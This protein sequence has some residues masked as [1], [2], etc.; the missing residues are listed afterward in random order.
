VGICLGVVVFLVL[1]FIFCRRRRRGNERDFT[2]IE[3]SIHKG[4]DITEALSGVIGQRRKP[5][6]QSPASEVSLDLFPV[7][8][9]QTISP[10]SRPSPPTFPRSPT[11]TSPS[12][13][14]SSRDDS[15]HDTVDPP[16]PIDQYPG[17]HMQSPRTVEPRNAP[18]P[19]FSRRSSV[20]RPSGPRPQSYRTSIGDPRTSVFTPLAQLVNEPDPTKVEELP[21][22]PEPKIQKVN[23]E[24][25]LI[26]YSF[27]DMN[28]TSR[29]SS[30]KEG[31]GKSRNSVP[32][33]PHANPDSP[34]R[35]PIVAS[36]PV[37]SHRDSD[38]HRESRNSKQ[39]SLS[40][41]I[42]QLPALKIRQS[43]ELHPYSP[44][45]PH[46]SRSHRP[47]TGGAS[48]TEGVP[49]TEVSEIRFFDA[50]ESSGSNG[51]LQRSRPHSRS[52]SPKPTTVT[53]QI[54]QKLFGSHQGE[55]P[56]DGLLAQKRP[57]RRKQLSVSTF[58]TPPRA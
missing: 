54:Y 11:L 10:L 29:T 36:D 2:F 30:I 20:P 19:G 41:V 40:A 50:G 51:S 31:P 37:R 27:L 21:E 8:I 6:A 3:P 49:V 4:Y 53:S 33:L 12:Q 32:P 57:L 24:G 43:T 47:P 55:V 16:E 23:E 35:P 28:S 38:R 46:T 56:P 44:R 14:K 1:G 5:H 13:T 7:T 42:R 15:G 25:E 45:P 26:T 18:S 34:P 39:L 9:P 58:N 48:P 52:P 22:N 17:P